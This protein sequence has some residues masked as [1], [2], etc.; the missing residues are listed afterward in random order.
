MES[1]NLITSTQ[2]IHSCRVRDDTRDFISVKNKHDTVRE[3]VGKPLV[4][5]LP[6]ESVIPVHVVNDP[7]NH[8]GYFILLDSNGVPVDVNSEDYNHIDQASMFTNN[9]NQDSKLNMITKA[10]N[11]LYGITRKDTTLNNIEEIY[12]MLVEDTINMKLKNGLYGDLVEVKDNTDLYRVMLMRALRAQQ[13]RLLFLPK[14]LV[15]YYAFDFRENGTGKSLLEKVAVLYSIRAILLF[16]TLMSTIKNNTNITEVTATLDEHD[17]DPE[18]TMEKIMSEILKTR[19]TML[20]L[21]VTKLED[22]TEWVHKLGF[23][24]NFKHPG[25]PDMQI[26]TANKSAGD[27]VIPDEGLSNDIKE[28]IIMSFGLTPEMIEAGYNVDFATTV[29]AKNLL[30]AKRVTQLQNILNPLIKDHIVKLL[31][32]DMVIVNTIK[33]IIKNNIVNIKKTIK[34]SLTNEEDGEESEDFSEEELI[35]YISD[36][37][38]NDMDIYLPSPELNEANAMKEA[39]TS[40]KTTMEEYIDSIINEEVLP[41]TLVGSLSS[42]IPNIQKIIKTILTK[43]WMSDNNYIPEVSEFLSLDD[44]GKPLYNF[45]EEYETYTKSLSSVIT[46]FLKSMIKEK[47]KTDKKLDGIIGDDSGGYDDGGDDS[48]GDDGFENEEGT[49][50]SDNLDNLEDTGKDNLD[51]EKLLADLYAENK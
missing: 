43:K 34:D 12:G 19:Q 2:W 47:D 51:S 22:L 3:S 16:S 18:K 11:A 31:S 41:D 1:S 36:L 20:P 24:F 27:N 50:D 45:L 46:P 30:L 49:G 28:H 14:E 4:M 23:K 35:E 33:D 39:F 29:V 6:T 17:P 9:M 5:K 13:T 21:G 25:L 8:L 26:E 10:K 38:I 32:N 42:T 15:A 7:S 44:E 37:Y 40:Y 48:S